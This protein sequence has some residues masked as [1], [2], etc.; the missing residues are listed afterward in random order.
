MSFHTENLVHTYISD[1]NRE[2]Q[3]RP[4]G[5]GR[6]TSRQEVRRAQE[7]RQAK[8]NLPFGALT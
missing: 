1:R 4:P 7:V 8:S 2:A 3:L 5:R 6:D